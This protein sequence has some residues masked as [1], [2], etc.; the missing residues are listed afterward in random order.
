MTE[1][2]KW[3]LF[4]RRHKT[5][6]TAANDNNK[7]HWAKAQN[8]GVLS[9]YPGMNAGAMVKRFDAEENKPDAASPGL[10]KRPWTTRLQ[11]QPGKQADTGHP[12]NHDAGFASG[13]A[14]TGRSRHSCGSRESI[15]GILVVEVSGNVGH[16][17]VG[18]RQNVMG[19]VRQVACRMYVQL[20]VRY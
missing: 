19:S 15:R 12:R 7:R 11:N 8:Y 10:R 5:S 16:T 18:N 3:G 13:T 20:V 14:T 4:L 2:N 6:N 9:L 1:E 17:V